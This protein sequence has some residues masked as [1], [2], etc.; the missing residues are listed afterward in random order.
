MG[1][2]R[3]RKI[4]RRVLAVAGTILGACTAAPASGGEAKYIQT[5]CEIS[6]SYFA[7]IITTAESQA[8]KANARK[9]SVEF[10]PERLIVRF[11]PAHYTLTWEDTS[12]V[13]AY[14]GDNSDRA[15]LSL[16][17]YGSSTNLRTRGIGEIRRDC[18]RQVK[19][20]IER[21]VH[22]PVHII[23]TVSGL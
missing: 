4:V 12:I 22:R 11:P 3:L 14:R 5:G 10:N 6:E 7:Y 15:T 1:H 2:I 18:W 9:Y 21:N 23:E 8:G 16:G 19:A 17:S 20:Y 13:V